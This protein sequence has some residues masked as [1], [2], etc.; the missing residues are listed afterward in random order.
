MRLKI[1]HTTRY[2]FDTGVRYGLWQLRKW[3]KSFRAQS[4]LTWQ[5]S[6]EGGR[7]ELQ[8]EDFNRNTVELMSV[9][10]GSRSVSIRSEGE[11]AMTDTHGVVGP[12]EGCAPL[13]LFRRGTEMTKSGP[14]TRDLV[15]RV[16]G[17]GLLDRLHAL[18]EV[19]RE[20]VTY[21]TGRSES[22]WSAED[23][24]SAGYGV[25][26][27]HTHVFLTC[28]RLMGVPARY[29]SGYLMMN[30]RISQEAM[31]AWAEAYV[32]GLGWVGFDISNA[33]SPDTRYVRVATGL[34]YAEAAPVSGMR[35][36][37]EG[38]SLTVA[39]EVAQQ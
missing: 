8:F 6:I 30:D 35:Y 31:H 24:V 4:V 1:T 22:D 38:E 7:K 18:S 21:E 27:D 23:V 39:V 3:P 20:A 16:E 11:V 5:T 15:R 14:G 28:A 17:D 9:E 10:P 36:G 34:D 13:W 29:V 2:E 26:Q 37:G 32:D 19:I 12:H 25:C 33:I